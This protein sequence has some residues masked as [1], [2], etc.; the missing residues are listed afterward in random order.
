[1]FGFY[2]LCFVVLKACRGTVYEEPVIEA[3]SATSVD[4]GTPLPEFEEGT[5]PT[6]PSGADFL[7]CYSTSQGNEH[8]VNINYNVCTLTKVSLF[9]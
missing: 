6:I 4:A 2:F 5:R 8:I 3:D 7:I 1:M 9:V